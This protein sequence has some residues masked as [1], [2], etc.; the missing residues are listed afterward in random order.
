[1]KTKYSLF[2]K[3]VFLSSVAALIPSKSHAIAYDLGK[4]ETDNDATSI[5]ST[6]ITDLT[7]KLR[8]K[9]NN[10]NTYLAMG[11]RSHSSHSSHASHSSHSSHYSSSPTGGS[12]GSS[13][14]GGSGTPTNSNDNSG[15]TNNQQTVHEWKLGDRILKKGMK[16]ADVKELIKILIQKGY[17][18][19]LVADI[20]DE[21]EFTLKVEESVKKFQK[22]NSLGAD[23]I[24]GA[25]TVLY[26]KK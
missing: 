4:L 17:F 7:P 21:T 2:L 22:A 10:D 13:G 9:F 15:N 12:G 20:F 14:T 8:I 18:V 25:T 16:G 5:S 26:L 11:H 1:M 23:G 6:K 24:V 3:N 19:K